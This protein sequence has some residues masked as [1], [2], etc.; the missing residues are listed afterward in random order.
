M[1]LAE[2]VKTDGV[3]GAQGAAQNR[4]PSCKSDM[5]ITLITPLKSVNF[6]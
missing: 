5:A 4:W 1:R 6:A 2:I 3:P